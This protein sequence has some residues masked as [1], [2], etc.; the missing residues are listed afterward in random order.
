V[1]RHESRWGVRQPTFVWRAV[2][3]S[4]PGQRYQQGAF[5]YRPP[6]V[7]L[8]FEQR[9]GAGGVEDD[10]LAEACPHALD[11]GL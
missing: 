6:G 3:D 4:R 8:V 5:G 7:A 10:A 2:G 1:S 11:D 9:L